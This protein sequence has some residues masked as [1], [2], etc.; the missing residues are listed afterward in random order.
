MNRGL[1]A[2]ALGAALVG[3][4]LSL[5]GFRFQGN[6][7]DCVVN[8]AAFNTEGGGCRDLSTGLVWSHQ[9][10]SNNSY[11][12]GVS[13]CANLTEGGQ[14]DW[15]LPTIG[16][17]EAVYANGAWTHLVFEHPYAHTWSSTKA[18]KQGDYYSLRF[19]DGNVA[20]RGT[21]R[22]SKNGLWLLP[23][24]CVRPTSP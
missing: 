20:I 2:I 19:S 24:I 7:G 15:R 1:R 22:G 5:T 14:T 3:M 6:P 4:F 21:K 18:N 12:Y 13:Y 8:D 9:D 10:G 16:E 17:L 23:N 11:E